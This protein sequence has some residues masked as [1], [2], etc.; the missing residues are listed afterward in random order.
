MIKS[1]CVNQKVLE[2][3]RSLLESAGIT[4][5]ELSVLSIL[6]WKIYT[7]CFHTVT[8]AGCKYYDCSLSE[9]QE[10]LPF[11]GMGSYNAYKYKLLKLQK[12]KLIT[13]PKKLK[14]GGRTYFKPHKSISVEE[15]VGKPKQE[16]KTADRHKNSLYKQ[17][18]KY[19]YAKYPDLDKELFKQ[20]YS[21]LRKQLLGTDYKYV[22]L[23]AA[24]SVRNEGLET[25]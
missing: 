12:A 10:D 6:F 9:I 2:D 8:I 20:H 18:L 16:R 23:L 3:R 22:G 4:Y 17:E 15:W 1:I 25:I 13:L 11:T 5:N 24:Q 19:M 7:N 21:N 14:K